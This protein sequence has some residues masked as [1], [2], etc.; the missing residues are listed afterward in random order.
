[1]ENPIVEPG[2]WSERYASE[3]LS[4]LRIVTAALFLQHGMTKI[5]GFPWSSASL[6]SMWSLLWVAGLI[7]LV[8][9]LLLLIGLF[10][11]PV[12]LLLSGEMAVGYFM[13]HAPQSTYPMLNGGESAVLFCF[14]FLYIAFEGAGPWSID[15]IL[16]RKHSE[17]GDG[18]YAAKHQTVVD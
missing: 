11:R 7:E 1:M 6:P 12:A 10:S 2:G 4:I 15:A 8:G 18:Y 5:L 9:S 13:I 16:K 14:I 17:A 3:V